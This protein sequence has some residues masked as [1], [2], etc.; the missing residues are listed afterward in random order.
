MR[1]RR[2]AVLVLL[3]W[4]TAVAGCGDD[5]EAAGTGGGQL[6]L[7]APAVRWVDGPEETDSA[8]AQVRGTLRIAD[9]CTR[10][11]LDGQ[12]YGLI[13]PAGTEGDDTSITPPGGE[14]AEDGST[15]DGGGGFATVSA[16]DSLSA[17]WVELVGDQ[18]AADVDEVAWFNPEGDITVRTA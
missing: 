16:S 2:P 8:E 7:D 18:C 4:A 14:T 15:V 17:E 12:V 1:T 3:L 11:D 10:L 13:W 5:D 6:E 9:G